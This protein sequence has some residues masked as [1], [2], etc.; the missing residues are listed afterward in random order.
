[1]TRH[2]DSWCESHAPGRLLV[3]EVSRNRAPERLRVRPGISGTHAA[4]RPADHAGLA[5]PV[6]HHM[7]SADGRSSHATILM[8][9]MIATP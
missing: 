1:M 2:T 3:N 5:G 6:E 8:A 9:R 4:G 7:K